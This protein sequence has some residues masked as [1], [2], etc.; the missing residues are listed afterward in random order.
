MCFSANVSFTSAVV[1][2][3]AGLYCLNRALYMSKPYWAFALLPIAF[4]IQ[5]LFEGFVWRAIEF[6]N[7]GVL[8]LSALGFLFFSHF[9]W[10]IWIPFSCYLI[11]NIYQRKSLFLLMA[12][13]GAAFGALMY[14]PLLINP[15]W[16]EVSVVNHSL[17]YQTT[18]VY[19]DYISREF[20]IA[21]YTLILMPLLLSS[22]RHLWLFGVLIF[23]SMIMSLTIY[24]YAFFSVWCFF[25]A[26]ISLYVYYVIIIKTQAEE[27]QT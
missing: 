14:I 6:D 17:F 8:R 1:L 18:L 7:A 26:M 24:R 16:L 20:G 22:D 2:V 21:A 5:Q 19:D 3:P 11:E 25:A 15:H 27:C 23:L 10:L 12:G 4:G 9:F 13:I